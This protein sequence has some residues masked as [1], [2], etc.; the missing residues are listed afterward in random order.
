MK[1]LTIHSIIRNEP[2]IYYSIKSVYDIADIILLYDT[3]SYD[4]YTL[5]DIKRL[6][7]E[8]IDK[9]I[10]FKQVHIDIDETKWTVENLKEMIKNN[11]GK[12][13]KSSVRKQQILDTTTEFFMIVDGDEVHYK[14]SLNSI[15]NII[16]SWKE[17]KICCYLPLI[18]FCDLMGSVA[19]V[20]SPVGRIFR[21]KDIWLTDNNP[22]E[23]HIEKKTKAK[24]GLY[25]NSKVFSATIPIPFAHFEMVLKPYR[26]NKNNY[27]IEKSNYQLP[28]VMRENP[29]FIE[30]FKREH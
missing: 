26:R 22:N 28:D 3:G 6:I 27:T 8:D 24:L 2:F 11:K 15:R 21:T 16:S 4:K 13:G 18:W 29:Y 17:D 19:K 5:K 7:D 25:T 20:Y 1:K 9:K 23:L 30:R 12:K 14:E 10:I